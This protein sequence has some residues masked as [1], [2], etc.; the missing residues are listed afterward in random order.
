MCTSIQL[1][2][3]VRSLSTC[4]LGLGEGGSGVEGGQFTYVDSGLVE[5]GDGG[6][7][8]RHE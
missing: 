3:L 7:T 6:A 1:I 8:W 2:T 5:C 4:A